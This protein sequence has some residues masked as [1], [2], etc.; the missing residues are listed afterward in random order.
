[1]QQKTW[2]IVFRNALRN[3]LMKRAKCRVLLFT[4]DLTNERLIRK[5]PFCQ[6]WGKLILNIRSKILEE[7]DETIVWSLHMFDETSFCVE[8]VP[9]CK[10][11]LM[12]L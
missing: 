1:M 11:T 5:N 7:T 2:I 6:Y 4:A 3:E 9:V 8:L 10:P 12:F